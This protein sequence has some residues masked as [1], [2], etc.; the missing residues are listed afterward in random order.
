MQTE[1]GSIPSLIHCE[2][3]SLTGVYFVAALVV[4]CH[5]RPGPSQ[6]DDRGCEVFEGRAA[7]RDGHAV[8]GDGSGFGGRVVESVLRRHPFADRHPDLFTEG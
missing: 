4:L 2:W 3:Q 1:T 5:L 7:V 8:V 6:A